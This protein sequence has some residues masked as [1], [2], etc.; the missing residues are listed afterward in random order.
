M[1]FLH[2][3]VRFYHVRAFVF[4]LNLV[5]FYFDLYLEFLNSSLFRF[6]R[7]WSIVWCYIICFLSQSSSTCVFQH[8]DIGNTC[9]A[10]TTQLRQDPDFFLAVD[11]NSRDKPEAQSLLIS[12][13][14]PYATKEN[15]S[16]NVTTDHHSNYYNH[17]SFRLLSVLQALWKVTWLHVLEKNS[18]GPN[19]KCKSL[20]E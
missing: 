12:P 20:N 4:F 6:D 17:I 5:I 9:I 15:N 18:N 13:N 7:G 16:V 1:F 3:F 11:L 19:W 10:R 14:L 8:D 2:L